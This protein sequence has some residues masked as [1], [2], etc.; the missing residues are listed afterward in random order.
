[1]AEKAKKAKKKVSAGKVVG[2]TIKFL[3]CPPYAIGEWISEAVDKKAAQKEA[4]DNTMDKKK[5]EEVCKATGQM[6]AEE[7]KPKT[8]E[9]KE[10]KEEVKEE[11][12]DEDKKT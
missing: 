9:A 12:K 3:A 1:M 8:E 2:E 11:V 7:L 5:Y 4:A 6:T 10:P